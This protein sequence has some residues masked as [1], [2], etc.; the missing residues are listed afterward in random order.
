MITVNH[1]SRYPKGT[2]D[3]GLKYD[4]NKKIKLH[5]YVDSGWVGMATDRISTS[6]CCFSLG[7]CMI[8]WFSRKKSCVA[9][10]TAEAEYAVA[11][12]DSCEVVWP[13]KLL[14]NLFYL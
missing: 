9:L 13:M 6:S 12:S 3:Y 14:S 10:S 2:V 1:V 11:C 4:A 5:G 7:S 8:S